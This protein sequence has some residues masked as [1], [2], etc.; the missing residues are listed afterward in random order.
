[1]RDSG[2]S[3]SVSP[4]GS[5]KTNLF[6]WEA[7]KAIAQ[8][9]RVLV[10]V[11]QN[12][13][14][15]QPKERMEQLT[16]I[17]AQV[18]KAEWIANH[19]SDFTIATVQTLK[20]R[21]EK[22]QPDEFGLII[23]DESDKSISP[24]WQTVLQHFNAR[25]L[26][27]T[28]TP[29][30]TDKRNLGIYYENC[31]E[32]ENLKSLIN[33]GYLSPIKI[34]MLPIKIDLSGRGAGKDF[35]D[36]EADEIITPHLE[37]IARAI[38]KHACFRRTL[39]FLPLIKTCERFNSIAREIGLNSDYVYGADPFRDDKIRNFKDWK[40]DVLANAM[41]LTR[42]VDIPETDCIVP[43]RPTKSVTLYFQM[44]GR[45]TRIASRKEDCLLLDFLY[46]AS[47]RL[48]CRP[49]HLLA[50]TDEERDAITKLAEDAS[51]A[52]PADVVAQLDLMELVNTATSQR[53]ESLRKKLEENKNKAAKTISA[54]EFAM[55]F[56][57]LETAEFEP[58]MAWESKPV[59]EK[60]KKY[61]G[62]AG[63]SLESVNGVAHASQLLSL[64]FANKTLKLASHG[65]RATMKRMGHPNWESATEQEAKQFF[66]GLKQKS[67][68][69]EFI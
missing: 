48:V 56:N 55:K 42:G 38:Q 59:T 39:C 68:Q 53:E 62:Q 23:C 69:P 45:G 66:A 65:Q 37:E 32:L 64:Y 4:T 14:V 51:Q 41:L 18:E 19:H 17:V 40:I 12:E 26:G 22:Y 50:Q 27:F 10:L 28:A 36:N 57:S 5:G 47:K 58:T 44:V 7:E 43:C 8:F 9:Q 25:V 1:M 16:G 15:W 49:A 24:M 34:Q 2:G 35:T 20:G 30:R 54:E 52:L 33:K 11:D 3:L 63:I 29:H 31:I 6:C 21:L 13:L 61:L 67:K 60:Q 46:Q